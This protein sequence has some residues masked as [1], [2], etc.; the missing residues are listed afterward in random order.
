MRQEVRP[1]KAQTETGAPLRGAAPIC[2][3]WAPTKGGWFPLGA[4]RLHAELPQL[5][6][7]PLSPFPGWR[8]PHLRT[9]GVKIGAIVCLTCSYLLL[10]VETCQNTAAPSLP[11]GGG[12]DR[13][14]I[15]PGPRPL[16]T[17]GKGSAVPGSR[18]RP[19]AEAG[20]GR[21]T[22]S[23]SSFESQP[24]ACRPH[25]ASASR[26]KC[27]TDRLFLQPGSQMGLPTRSP[28]VRNGRTARTLVP[29]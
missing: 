12:G 28:A 5:P 11:S 20:L 24:E 29:G 13:C 8:G 6:Q 27:P 21:T 16:A 26:Q 9:A 7:G 2:S 19:P 1:L 23:G 3:Q 25:S 14:H 17:V 4:V 10:G 22:F 15:P 18:R